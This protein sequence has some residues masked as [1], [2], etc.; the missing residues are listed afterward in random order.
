MASQRDVAKHLGISQ[1]RV[2]QLINR[3]V[4]PYADP[5]DYSL[6]TCRHAFEV[7]EEHAQRCAA[8]GIPTWAWMLEWHN[9]KMREI[10][11]QEW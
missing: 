3:G 5:G 11:D 1:P 7:W 10:C 4:L 6:S 9:R 2:N 8:R